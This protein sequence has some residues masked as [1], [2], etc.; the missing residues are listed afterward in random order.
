L[1]A[2]RSALVHGDGELLG[3]SP[4][5]ISVL[6]AAIRVIAPQSPSSQAA[7]KF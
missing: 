1:T 2:D 5:E 7:W 4:V 6:P 3:E